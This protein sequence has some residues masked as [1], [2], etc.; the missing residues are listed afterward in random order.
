MLAQLVTPIQDSRS[1]SMKRQGVLAKDQLGIIIIIINLII[2]I[3]K[4]DLKARG[5]YWEKKTKL[6][7]A[8]LL[9][10]EL[11]HNIGMQ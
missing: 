3:I 5:P 7:A 4:T 6:A 2:I 11:G 10:H 9:A 1:T 8:R